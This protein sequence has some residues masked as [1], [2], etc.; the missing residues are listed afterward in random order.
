MWESAETPT[1]HFEDILNYRSIYLA[2]RNV[3]VKYIDW[4]Q[5]IS[6]DSLSQ[7]LPPQAKGQVPSYV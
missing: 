7:T 2:I 3:N 1:A 6:D 4:L 5:Q